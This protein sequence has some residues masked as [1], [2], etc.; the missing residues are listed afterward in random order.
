MTEHQAQREAPAAEQ[1]T[2][3]EEARLEPRIYVASLADYNAGRLHGRWLDATLTP[4]ELQEGIQAMLARSPEPVAEDWAIHD[5]DGFAGIRLD[6]FE[7]LDTISRLGQGLAEHGPA[8]AGLVELLGADEATEAAFCE[9]YQGHWRSLTLY[10]E[11]L[12]ESC[13]ADQHLEQI[14]SPLRRYV[15]IDVDCLVRDL[16][17][18]GVIYTATDAEGINVFS[19]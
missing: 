14:P 3:A 7:S 19:V 13:S 8:F 12:L 2:S 15:R 18:E 10:A 1:D 9:R 16:Q 4:E 6:E 5:H 17:A 11:E